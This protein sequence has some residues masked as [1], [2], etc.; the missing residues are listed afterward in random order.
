MVGMPYP[1]IKSPELK[2][3]IDYLNSNFVSV[4]DSHIFIIS[5][6]YKEFYSTLLS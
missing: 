1:N 4:Y 6:I 3:K 2:E 5:H